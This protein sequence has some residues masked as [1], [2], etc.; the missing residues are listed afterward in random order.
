[1]YRINTDGVIWQTWFRLKPEYLQQ[2]AAHSKLCALTVRL[3]ECQICKQRN[4]E[5]AGEETFSQKLFSREMQRC[6]QSIFCR[7]YNLDVVSIL[8]V[9]RLDLPKF[10]VNDL[11]QNKPHTPFNRNAISLANNKFFFSFYHNPNIHTLNSI[12]ILLIGIK[13]I[14]CFNV[15]N[16]LAFQIVEIKYITHDW[17]F[18]N[19][20]YNCLTGWTADRY[21]Q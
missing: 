8:N 3:A 6:C 11:L 17:S 2:N 18:F 10:L 13:C 4:L 16:I 15:S 1:M 7:E 21:L 5:A 20:L 9:N 14:N 19:F 12:K